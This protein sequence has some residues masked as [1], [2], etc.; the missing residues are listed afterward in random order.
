EKFQAHVQ[1]LKD[2]R[3][4]LQGLKMAEEGKSLDFLERVERERQKVVS[5]V[6]ELH[7]LVEG[8]ERL[9]L[10][11]LAKL[12]QEIT[13]R[14]EENINRL[15]EEISSVGEQI[16]ELEEKCQQPACEF[17]QDSRNILS[18]LEKDGAQKPA[19][20][21]AE[22]G[23]EPTGF[24]QK[25]IALKETLMK[26]QASL[27]L[28]PDTAHPRLVLSADRKRVR[29]EDTRQPVPDHP[30][31]FDASRCVLGREGFGGGRHYWE[32]EVGDGEAWAVG[33]AKESVGRKG[34]I[35]VNLKVGIWAVVGQCGSRYQALT[36]PTIPITLPVAPKVIGIY[37]DYEEGR[38]AFFD[39]NN[40]T[41]IFT[42]PPTSFAGEKILP[43]LCLGRGCRFTLS[44]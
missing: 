42:Y 35:S 17:L 14:Q 25:N 34:R 26:F 15:L 30:K 8:Q 43:L 19:E 24:P 41:P 21:S 18:R 1:I 16:R 6:K 2:R 28:D 44:P 20:T 11:R 5:E 7:Q 38:V 40:E 33:V 27:T 10:E 23:E 37:L 29:W 12:D 22:P 3:E 32:V 13:R 36:S 31:R 9:L 4:K 39:S